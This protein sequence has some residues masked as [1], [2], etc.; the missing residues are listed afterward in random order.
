MAEASGLV[1]D[2]V[3]RV[4]AAVV[5]AAGGDEGQDLVSPLSKGSAEAGDLGD[6][7]G[8]QGVD[9]LKGAIGRARTAARPLTECVVRVL[10][11]IPW[12]QYS[13]VQIWAGY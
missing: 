1:D 7:A 11:V 6:G 8:V 13:F 12:T 3:E 2:E 10:P 4:G 5:D 9:R